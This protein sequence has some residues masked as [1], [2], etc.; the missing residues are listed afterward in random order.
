MKGT[1][2]SEL[3]G[4]KQL[5]VLDLSNNQLEGSVPDA[6]NAF[7]DL[8]ILDLSH[9]QMQQQLPHSVGEL[10]RLE[11]LRLHHNYFTGTIPTEWGGMTALQTL[12]MVCTVCYSCPFCPLHDALSACMY[13]MSYTY[14]FC[15]FHPF[16]LIY[17]F[18]N[19]VLEQQP[20]QWHVAIS[21]G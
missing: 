8:R 11:E 12:T 6:F 14:Y 5:Q 10:T 2:L 7:A 19:S 18:L 9:N 16:L 13:N 15:E 20:N 3:A 17:A 1:L 4:A 21:I